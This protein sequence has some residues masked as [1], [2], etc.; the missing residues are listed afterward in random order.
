MVTIIVDKVVWIKICQLEHAFNILDKAKY[1]VEYYWLRLCAF[2][3]LFNMDEALVFNI[4][5]LN[6]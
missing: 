3:C 4:N 2:L 5:I 1:Y 6:I